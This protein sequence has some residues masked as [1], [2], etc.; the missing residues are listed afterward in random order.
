MGEPAHP[1]HIYIVLSPFREVVPE[2]H[3]LLQPLEGADPYLPRVEGYYNELNDSALLALQF[4]RD[5]VDRCGPD[6]LIQLISQC[7]LPIV[8][9]DLLDDDSRA[10]FYATHLTTYSTYL[11]QYRTPDET[12]PL[13]RRVLAALSEHVSGLPEPASDEPYDSIEISTESPRSRARTSSKWEYDL[14]PVRRKRSTS[15]WDTLLD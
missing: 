10:E 1:F 9:P 15:K 3:I 6:V 7:N 2:L 14:E 4:E 5:L 11:Q 12:M 8:T 13:L